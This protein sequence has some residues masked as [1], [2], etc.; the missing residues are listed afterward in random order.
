M[1]I[2]NM[3]A[4]ALTK[5]GLVTEDNYLVSWRLLS[6]ISRFTKQKE[7][8]NRLISKQFIENILFV[9]IGKQITEKIEAAFKTFE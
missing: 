6:C 2:W 9:S 8:Y 3:V 1:L 5:E 7:L 4:Y